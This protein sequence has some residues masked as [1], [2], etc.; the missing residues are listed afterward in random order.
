MKFCLGEFILSRS[1]GLT[2]GMKILVNTLHCE[3]NCRKT[4]I[5]LQNNECT[6]AK[7]C[8]VLRTLEQCNQL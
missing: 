4:C 8:Y 7:A 3:L 6:S 5:Q 1:S 2:S